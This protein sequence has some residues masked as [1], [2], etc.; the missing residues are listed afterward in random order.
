MKK[1]LIVTFW[2]LVG[3]FAFGVG[4]FI[5]PLLRGPLFLVPFLVFFLLGIALLVL[6]LKEKMAGKLKKFL[7]LTSASAIGFF[8]FILLH[9][10]VYALFIYFFGEN[11]W[12]RI[13]L[14]DE[15]FFFFLA[16]IVCPIG[17]LIGVVGSGTLLLKRKL[18]KAS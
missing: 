11:F 16:I 14:G 3:V 9:N 13:G 8:L 7:L 12:E 6:T 18:R 4:Q 10:L 15:R 17:F 2:L 1:S 5:T